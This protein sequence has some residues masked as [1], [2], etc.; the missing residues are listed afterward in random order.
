M[1]PRACPNTGLS[2]LASGAVE[3][4]RE[5]GEDGYARITRHGRGESLA[6]PGFADVVVAVADVLPPRAS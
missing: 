3:V 4:H 1:R 6:V 2:I 5:P